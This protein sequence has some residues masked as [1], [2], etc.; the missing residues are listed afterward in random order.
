MMGQ[1]VERPVSV[2]VWGSPCWLGRVTT[3]V[4]GTGPRHRGW[5]LITESRH[6][7]R[8]RPCSN[9]KTADGGIGEEV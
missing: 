7:N 1:K 9:A 6:R 8:L 3:L 4:Q 5:A 2:Y